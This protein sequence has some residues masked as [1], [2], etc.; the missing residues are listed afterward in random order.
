MIIANAESNHP[1]VEVDLSAKWA[2]GI[3]TMTSTAAFSARSQEI[4]LCVR[5]GSRPIRTSNMYG[6]MGTMKLAKNVSVD[7]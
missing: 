3:R 4:V 5:D 7:G 1:R 2:S 6:R